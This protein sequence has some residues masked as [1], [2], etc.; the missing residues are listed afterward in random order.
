MK[1]HWILSTLFLLNSSC[2]A[3]DSNV[4]DLD[5]QHSE[6]L[7]NW[8]ETSGGYFHPALE[9]RRIDP[10]NPSSHFGMFA[11]HDIKNN[12]RLIQVPYKMTINADWNPHYEGPESPM[13]C[14]TVWNLIAQIKKGKESFH[15]PYVHYLQDTQ[16]PGIIPS[17]WSHEGKRLLHKVL[18]G[19]YKYPG[20]L[21]QEEEDKIPE[22]FIELPPDEP[23]VW[24]NEWVES[25]GGNDDPL[26][27]YA[28]LALIN[29]GWDDIMI[30]LIDMQSHRNGKYTNTRH[31]ALHEGNDPILYASRD[32]KAGEE[33]NTSYN[34]CGHDCG[35]RTDIYGTPEILRDYGFV[36]QMPQSWN[37][38]ELDLG[39]HIDYVYE[40]DGGRPVQNRSR[41]ESYEIVAWTNEED[42]DEND[43]DLLQERL[44]QTRETLDEI[45]SRDKHQDV[46]ENEYNII[47]DYMENMELALEVAISTIYDLLYEDDEEDIRNREEL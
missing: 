1:F 27:Q 43:M 10:E 37:F 19:T 23:L 18:T 9:M 34:Q 31:N 46:P 20:S 39:F 11:N 4:I 13:T 33:I 44:D 32:I 42:A 30:P 22:G 3:D 24:Q 25:C 17:A 15:Y 45:L 38:W 2:V 14:E 36:E 29:R 47:V 16:P 21:A 41:K 6:S 5:K 28:A 12:T 40:D 7:I 8:L 35:G 26:E